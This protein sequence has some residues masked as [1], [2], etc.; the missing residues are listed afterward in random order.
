[1]NVR[2][3]LRRMRGSVRLRV[4]LI[5][6]ATIA[7]TLTA[8]SLVLLN[9]LE[10]RLVGQIR[11]G[12][13][14]LLERNA[15]QLASGEIGMS[16]QQP[17]G[18]AL[19]VTYKI[20]R[21][22][23]F[24]TLITNAGDL[25]LSPGAVSGAATGTTGPGT[26]VQRFVDGSSTTAQNLPGTAELLG[27]V[28]PGGSQ[29]RVLVTQYALPSGVSLVTAS[30]LA[31]VERTLDTTRTLLWFGVPLLVLLVAALA[32]F[33]VGRALRP[34]HAV[35]SQVAAIG[36]DSLHERVPVPAT[37]DEVNELAET[38]NSMLDRLEAATLTGRR[39][40]SDAAHELRTPIAVMRAEL[41]VARTQPD[42][43]WPAV[44][45]AL[46]VE[47]E[48]LRSL[49]DDLVLIAR[50][51]ERCPV[52]ERF[53]IADAVRDVGGRRR[54]VEVHLDLDGSVVPDLDVGGDPL[55][56]RQALDH[57]VA[58]AARHAA[59]RV[60]VWV[61]VEAD[62]VSI[63]VDDDGPG[64]APADRQRVLCRFVRLDEG[65]SRDA[66]GSGLGLAVASEVAAAHGGRVTIG[67]SPSGGARVSLTVSRARV[68]APA[69]G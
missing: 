27:E 58:N 8:V 7:V 37:G 45:R 9:V 64:I 65:R 11:D 69:P 12:D 10:S 1:M 46:E 42:T 18:A 36:A 56:V 55:A 6:V 60:D 33:L 23:G 48:R 68:L 21:D 67:E 13:R 47:V 40:V 3:S 43:D 4:T 22:G 25:S 26:F 51:S 53:S 66:G 28:G 5:A 16:T 14:A 54:S 41:E 17:T 35:T 61:A 44:G 52:V 50:M 2:A 29:T 62:A 49:V 24:P 32:W 20:P 63:H 15:E 57:I 30:S 31:E 34:V 19:D 38:M 59:S 39:L